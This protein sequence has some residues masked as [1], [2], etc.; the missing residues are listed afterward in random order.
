LGQKQTSEGALLESAS[1]PK[2][3]MQA[4]AKNVR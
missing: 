2:A 1:S 3:D 4:S